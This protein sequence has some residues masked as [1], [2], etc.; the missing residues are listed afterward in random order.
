MKLLKLLEES[1]FYLYVMSFLNALTHKFKIYLYKILY[2]LLFF[3][4]LF[5]YSLLSSI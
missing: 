4:Y 5:Y 3:I 2:F 1:Y